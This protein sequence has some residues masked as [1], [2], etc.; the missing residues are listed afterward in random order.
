MFW[1]CSFSLLDKLG[2]GGLAWRHWDC[3]RICDAAITSGEFSLHFIAVADEEGEFVFEVLDVFCDPPNL[4]GPVVG[5]CGECTFLPIGAS[6]AAVLLA[7][8]F[9]QL[10]LESFNLFEQSRFIECAIGRAVHAK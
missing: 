3:R 6:F 10:P 9:L 8:R 7:E 2:D 5:F 4:V 1:S